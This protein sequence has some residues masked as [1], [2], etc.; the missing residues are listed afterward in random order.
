[1][2]EKVWETSNE[3]KLPLIKKKKKLL[4]LNPKERQGV[5]YYCSLYVDAALN[6]SH[7][8]MDLLITRH[9]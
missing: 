2:K 3:Q 5:A 8:R 9:R 1:M 4:E 6:Y 7:P